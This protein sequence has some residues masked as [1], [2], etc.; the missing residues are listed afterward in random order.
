MLITTPSIPQ[1]LAR[2]LSLL[3]EVKEWSEKKINP[4]DIMET[5]PEVMVVGRNDITQPLLTAIKEYPFVKIVTDCGFEIPGSYQIKSMPLGFDCTFPRPN[6]D[7]PEYEITVVGSPDKIMKRLIEP[8]ILPLNIKTFGHHWPGENNCGVISNPAR[9][10]LVWSNSG[11]T[12]LSQSVINEDTYR[13]IYF[14]GRVFGVCEQVNHISEDSLR[15]FTERTS[16]EYIKNFA[17]HTMLDEWCDF[18][19]LSPGAFTKAFTEK[20]PHA[21]QF[22]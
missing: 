6:N 10:P 7:S 13:A 1:G 21:N 3:Y 15:G 9:W 4:F 2:N 19:H 12:I 14:C 5:S 16:D 22:V 18:L 11:K 20:V 17:Y 8:L